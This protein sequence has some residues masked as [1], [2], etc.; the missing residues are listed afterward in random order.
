MAMIKSKRVRAVGCLAAS[1]AIATYLYDVSYMSEF[2][3][4][5]KH[6]II[7]S[8]QPIMDGQLLRSRQVGLPEFQ[9]SREQLAMARERGMLDRVGINTRLIVNPSE[10]D[11]RAVKTALYL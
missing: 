10:S 7:V 8:E 3:E 5:G 9:H 2:D 6:D 4:L 1:S 11:A